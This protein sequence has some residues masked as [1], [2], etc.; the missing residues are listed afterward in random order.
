MIDSQKIEKESYLNNISA[1]CS[2]EK[3]PLDDSITF[4]VGENGSGKSTLLEAIAIAY[5]FNP[6]GGTKN[7]NFCTRATH[8]N[9]EKAITLVKGT[10][11]PKDGF[12]FRA[13]SFYNVAS[14]IDN[15]AGGGDSYLKYYGGKSLHCQSHGE[16]LI[17]LVLNKFG[18]DGLYILDE[19]EAALSPQRL[20][21]LMIAI[22]K[23]I[24]KNAQF[25]IATH[26]PILLG[27]PKASILSFDDGKIHKIKYEDA[28]CYKITKMFLDNRKQ[29]LE[30]LL[31]TE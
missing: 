18:G 11:K 2:I 4:F 21:S 28:E 22:S 19:P 12:F 5:G 25:I 31:N 29:L 10:K 15:L 17:S 23:L 20:L 13:E 3:L 7:F 26:S 8:S 24:E 6:E 30:K 9:L 1:I 16:S 27:I 14:E